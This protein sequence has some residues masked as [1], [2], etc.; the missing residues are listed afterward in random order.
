MYIAKQTHLK[1]CV[2]AI[3]TGLRSI[4]SNHSFYSPTF[5]E[6]TPQ[7]FL[8]WNVYFCERQTIRVFYL[9]TWY[10]QLDSTFCEKNVF[11]FSCNSEILRFLSD[12]VDID[13]E[14][15]SS[16]GSED[17]IVVPK[18]FD[19]NSPLDEKIIL[20]HKMT[21]HEEH[22]GRCMRSDFLLSCLS[23]RIWNEKKAAIFISQKHL[24][25]Y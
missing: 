16:N 19:F 8:L 4:N 22:H 9:L 5:A 21:C 25:V 13:A 11:A 12:L 14:S 15:I 10:Q 3:V 6:L 18:F 20:Q 23:M 1:V 24:R 17:F 7:C 2:T